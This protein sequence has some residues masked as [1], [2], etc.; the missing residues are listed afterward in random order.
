MCRA[1]ASKRLAKKRRVDWHP[2][3]LTMESKHPSTPIFF[4]FVVRCYR[5]TQQRLSLRFGSDS[6]DGPWPTG[7]SGKKA[8]SAGSLRHSNSWR[9]VL[10]PEVR[11]QLV[12]GESVCVVV[13]VKHMASQ[14]NATV[15]MNRVFVLDI[16]TVIVF[17]RCLSQQEVGELGPTKRLIVRTNVGYV[18]SFQH[19]LEVLRGVGFQ[20]LAQGLAQIAA[21]ALPVA[22]PVHPEVDVGLGV[23]FQNNAG[24]STHLAEEELKGEGGKRMLGLRMLGLRNIGGKRRGFNFY[25][26]FVS[27]VFV[28]H[29]KNSCESY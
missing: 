20:E 15:H 18:K 12:K 27:F 1:I 21:L 25:D 13:L 23:A 2:R 9:N 17:V 5:S 11:F 14:N 7:S 24:S 16:V 28:G 3:L 10:K 4:A 6:T 26:P 19:R 8:M 22:V 29:S